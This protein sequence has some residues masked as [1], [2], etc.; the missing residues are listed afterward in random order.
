ME[1]K[2][3]TIVR[4]IA[5]AIGGLNVLLSIWGVSPLPFGED[6]VYM[7][8]SAI[9][10]AVFVIWAWWKNNSFTDA[11]KEGDKV[12]KAIKSGMVTLKTVD[13]ALGV[14]DTYKREGTD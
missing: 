2:A 14:Q 13:R 12:L 10:E 9:V 7:S 8:L 6:A 5:T 3:S 4:T 1:T 11:A